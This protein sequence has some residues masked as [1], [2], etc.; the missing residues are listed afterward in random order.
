[1]TTF[2]IEQIV[3]LFATATPLQ[4]NW[5]CPALVSDDPAASGIRCGFPDDKGHKAHARDSESL[6][7]TNLHVEGGE[8][9]AAITSF[10]V[11]RSVYFAFFGKLAE[12][13]TSG[14]PDCPP[15]QHAVTEAVVS[16]PSRES[17]A[18]PGSEDGTRGNLQERPGTFEGATFALREQQVSVE[19]GNDV[20]DGVNFFSPSERIQRR[21]THMDVERI[22]AS[23][24]AGI[25]EDPDGRSHEA[26]AA[27]NLEE[28]GDSYRDLIGTDNVIPAGD[29]QPGEQDPDRQLQIM[30]FSHSKVRIEF[31]I[32]ERDV[33]KTDRSLLVDPSELSEVERVAKKYMR[34]GFKPFDTSFSLLVP[35]TCLQAVT[36]DG[37]NT[38]LLIPE[39]DIRVNNQLVAFEPASN[40]G[41]STASRLKKGRY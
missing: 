27:G 6:F 25:R 39:N 28:L 40:A 38:V 3:G 31:K 12:I 9:G 19:D 14:R 11:R 4:A 10:S 22:I 37:T 7:I 41:P 13:S 15:P 8:V 36:A 2:H 29:R 23:G 1:M 35:R 34:K 30:A 33:W 17:H 21:G 26:Q 16:P 18:N 20:Q 5:S 24:L 32:H